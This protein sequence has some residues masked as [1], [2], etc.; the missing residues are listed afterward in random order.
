MERCGA[1]VPEDEIKEVVQSCPICRVWR[2]PTNA[3]T[4]RTTLPDAHNKQAQFDYLFYKTGCIGHHIDARTRWSL[5]KDTPGREVQDCVDCTNGWVHLFG[6]MVE[7]WSDQESAVAAD[8]FGLY[9]QRLGMKRK[10]VPK[11]AHMDLVERHNGLIRNIM[12][13]LDE[14][15][16]QNGLTLSLRELHELACSAKN[17]T[18]EYG[19]FT[20]NHQLFGNQP[21]WSRAECDR[22][23]DGIFADAFFKR[24]L[25]LRA[26]AMA[27]YEE[28]LSRSLRGHTVTA[29]R[30]D[31]PPG[32][33]IDVHAETKLKD[34][35][36]WRGP[37]T[38]IANSEEGIE[39]RWQS[40]IRKA[41]PWQCRSHVF[42]LHAL[43][44]D[45]L[46]NVQDDL[47]VLMDW[48]RRIAFGTSE[49]HGLLMWQ[50]EE[51]VSKAAQENC[52][53]ICKLSQQVALE[54]FGLAFCMGAAL[55]RGLRRTP[56]VT[57]GGNCA[58]PLWRHDMPE[59]YEAFSGLSH[60]S[61]S[62]DKLIGQNDWQNR[63]GIMFYSYHRWE[64]S[65]DEMEKVL[66][67]NTQQNDEFQDCHSE[68][69]DGAVTPLS[70]TPAQTPQSTPAVTALTSTP[71]QTP[72]SSVATP[73][74]EVQNGGVAAATATA[75][76][77]PVSTT[78]VLSQSSTTTPVTPSSGQASTT[79]MPAVQ[80]PAARPPS[81]AGTATATSSVPGAPPEAT[82]SSSSGRLPTAG[83]VAGGHAGSMVGSHVG[84]AIG[85]SV[86]EAVGGQVGNLL[87]E[88]MG[89]ALGQT[90]ASALPESGPP[91]PYEEGGEL[92]L[93]GRPNPVTVAEAL[94]PGPVDVGLERAVCRTLHARAYVAGEQKMEM[95]LSAAQD[96]YNISR[97]NSGSRI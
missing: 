17:A 84:S 72:S 74:S 28:R 30:E 42:M 5:T 23:R 92:F 10:L 37:C 29:N 3:P 35:P 82:S 57:D 54:R 94:D 43:L 33:E 78:P 77:V 69:D 45:V 19:G 63:C 27:I 41:A 73:P 31:F 93:P 95:A 21:D 32:T 76:D 6:P 60:I 65:A 59:K 67:R 51:T 80:L 15:A 9:P 87:G 11:D 55:W 22:E 44:T 12:R 62:V 64:M 25:A 61:H 18:V 56:A 26:A 91:Q 2:L 46:Y 4:F 36:N 34:G 75:A 79:A 97:N 83:R 53:K 47:M 48:A 96:D 70:S 71:L 89:Q 66:E 40:V 86:G 13:L 52:M 8:E 14:E 49:V 39:Y 58:I 24:T 81:T 1:E 7:L 16:K 50:Q 38:V 68:R 88:G 85:G 90:M 20:A